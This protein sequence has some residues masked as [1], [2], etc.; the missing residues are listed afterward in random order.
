[1]RKFE[2]CRGHYLNSANRL[3]CKIRA[4][5]R[6]TSAGWSPWMGRRRCRAMS[7]PSAVLA[8]VQ[9]VV[10]GAPPGGGGGDDAPNSDRGIIFSHTHKNPD[11]SSF[12]ATPRT[13]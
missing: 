10:G 6:P 4:I 1:M 3:P 2:S 13:D 12:E 5:L 8:V 7:V 9:G 11:G